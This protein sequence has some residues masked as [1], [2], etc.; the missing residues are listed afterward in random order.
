[1]TYLNNFQMFSFLMK[2]Y[3]YTLK[4]FFPHSA[5]LVSL[6]RNASVVNQK[7]AVTALWLK[8]SYLRADGRPWVM[9]LTV[10]RL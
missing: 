9:S 3:S 1:M 4:M 6:Q 8:P 2:K 5:S 10:G 7:H